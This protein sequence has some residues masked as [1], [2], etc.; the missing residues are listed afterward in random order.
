MKQIFF[1]TLLAAGITVFAQAHPAKAS[2]SPK[3][4]AKAISDEL[5]RM[6]S[7]RAASLK[8]SGNAVTPELFKETCGAVKKRAMEISKKEGVKI[9]HAAIKNRNPD[10]AA[11]EDEIKFHNFFNENSK[12]ESIW[13]KVTI[14]GKVYSRYVSPIYV[15]PGCLLCHGEK[16]K[17]PQFIQKKYPE[18]KAYGF[19]EGDLR[20][21]IEVM[22]PL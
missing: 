3:Q 20:G 13:N 14:E 18:D 7:E 21:I 10:H 9:R 15:E 22:L 11:T 12:E 5:T 8:E 16:E 1:V 6:R 19:K 17:R 4:K 2:D